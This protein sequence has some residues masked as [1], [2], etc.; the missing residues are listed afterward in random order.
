MSSTI[1]TS[2]PHFAAIVAAFFVEERKADPEGKIP[3]EDEVATS[4]VAA[5]E[6][7]AS[8]PETLERFAQ[9]FQSALPNQESVTAVVIEEAPEAKEILTSLDTTRIDGNHRQLKRIVEGAPFW[10]CKPDKQQ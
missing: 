5:F 4:A 3:T 7:Y 1:D 9:Y 10:T 2:H 6:I 8:D